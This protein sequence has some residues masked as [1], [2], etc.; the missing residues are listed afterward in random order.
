MKR[1]NLLISICNQSAMSATNRLR[2]STTFFATLLA[3]ML[4]GMAN[5]VQAQRDTTNAI[6][7]DISPREV[8]IR[9]ELQ[10]A[11]PSLVRQPLI[12]FNPPPR[13]P[14]LP[15]SRRPF[16]E[17]YKLASADLPNTPLG[18]PDPPEVSSLSDL[19]PITGEFEASIGRYL[20]RILRARISG[21]LNHRSSLYGR[22]DYQG[23]EGYFLEDSIDFPDLRNPY[24][25]LFALVGYQST[26]PRMGWGLAFDGNVNSYTLFGTN[27]L[28]SGVLSNQIILPDRNGLSG[29][30]EFW[31]QSQAGSNVD[32]E[33]RLK[34]GA[35]RYQTDLFDNA[36]NALP[37]LD[38]R[39]KRLTGV[40]NI[41]VP[42]SIGDFLVQTEAS[43]A[44]VDDESLFDFSTYY[45]N[46]ASGFNIEITP[47]FN[48]MVAGRYL[49]TSFV[50]GGEDQ[51]T[52]Y[53][54][55]DAQ[56][57][58]YPSPGVTLFV[59]NAPG[60]DRNT[61]WDVFR[62]SPYISDFPS[63]QSTIRPIDAEA[64]FKIFSGNVQMA[65]KA[66]YIQSPNYL[67]FES[68]ADQP[69]IPGYNYR[70]GI[71][72]Y[73]FEDTEILHADG[74]ISIS[75]SGDL[76]LKLGVSVREAKLTDTDVNV[77]YFSPIVSENMLS[78]TFSQKRMMLQLLTTYY[79]SRNRNRFDN[80]KVKDYFDIDLSYSYQIHAGLG[81]ILRVD[82]IIGNSVEHWEHYP[83]APFTVSAGMRVL[84]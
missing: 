10:I 66:G 73:E 22:I 6:L 17:A 27:L 29:N 43:G 37:R 52:S 25:G 62:S 72:N 70:R 60:I 36:L 67:F 56:I 81:F 77:P 71:F 84:W 32:T 23:S 28:D 79:S 13:V 53:F 24:D 69:G 58:L 3:V 47:K 80:S 55:A 41:S 14:E 50:E 76:H 9:G 64:G 75:F 38:Q 11:F 8:E 57:N 54:T 48:F 16:I 30:A 19:T 4:V 63:L 20:S 74:D 5:P 83:E 2:F 31:M 51:F 33:F 46:A 49:G 1:L 42:F 34:Y 35:T 15:A 68:E 78:Y 59:R 65:V 12:G 82:N 40:F 61:L 7:P 45:L 18:Q 44:G 21:S 39:E 26:G